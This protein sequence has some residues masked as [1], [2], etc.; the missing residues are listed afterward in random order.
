[1][2][3]NYKKLHNERRIHITNC[4]HHIHSYT[5]ILAK[6]LTQGFQL[7]FESILSVFYSNEKKLLPLLKRHTGYILI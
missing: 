6:I 5:F 2:Y 7:M 1:M 4:I 3:N